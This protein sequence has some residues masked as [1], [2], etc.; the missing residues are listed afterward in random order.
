MAGLHKFILMAWLMAYGHNGYA[1]VA[2]TPEDQADPAVVAQ[3]M[4]DERTPEHRSAPRVIA[5][6]GIPTVGPSQSYLVG[7]V[8]VE[9]ARALPLSAFAAVIDP[10]LGRELSPRELR[11][12]ASEIANVA[13][14]KGYGLATAWIPEQRLGNGILRVIIDEGGIDEVRVSGSAEAA[15]HRTLAPLATGHPLKMPQLERALLLAEDIA[16]V[17]LGKPRLE[18][19]RGRNIL[20]VHATRDRVQARMLIDNWG[21]APVGRLRTQLTLD[22]NGLLTGDDRLSISGMITPAQPRELGLVQLAYATLIGKGGTEITVRGQQPRTHPG[23]VLKDDD[24]RGR[25]SYVEVGIAHPLLRSRAT[26]LWASAQ[27]GLLDAAQRRSGAL[28]R[29]DRI[30]TAAATIYG[31]SSGRLG[32]ARLRITLTRG[33]DILG[34]TGGAHPLASRSDG[35]AIFSKLDAWAAYD[36]KLGGG[37]SVMF[38][39]EGQVASRPLLSSE[40]MGLG[41]R[42]FLRGYDYREFS[43][44]KGVAGSAEIRF[45]LAKPSVPVTAA[46]FYVYADAGAVGNYRDG[47][48]S[49][50]LASAGGGLRVR[51]TQRFDAS[52]EGGVPLRSGFESTSYKPR[53]SFVLAARL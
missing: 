42:Y 11:A 35:D 34:S 39:A 51:F 38:Q 43:G 4:Q 10:F 25:S 32:R 40:E 1:S 7:A 8:R 33:L 36:L 26:S 37:F 49:G 44:D 24:I 29:D 3:Q 5:P 9:G 53:L 23:G 28:F 2:H 30:A 19:R 41:G 20:V 6:S 27:L 48:G 45:D 47:G 46:Q 18:R 14:H 15:V 17:K 50:S 22:I 13:R 21:S 16:G 12:L 52:I 31:T